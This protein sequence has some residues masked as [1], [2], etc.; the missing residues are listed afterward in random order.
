[1]V[2]AILKDSGRHFDREKE[3]NSVLCAVLSYEKD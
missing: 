3:E 2:A 1:M